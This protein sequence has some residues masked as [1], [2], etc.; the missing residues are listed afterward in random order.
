MRRGFLLMS[1][2]GSGQ[3]LALVFLRYGNSTMNYKLLA[4][5]TTLACGPVFAVQGQVFTPR[6]M[7]SGLTF[8]MVP[9]NQF[10]EVDSKNGKSDDKK[11]IKKADKKAKN[12]SK[13]S[14]ADENVKQSKNDHSRDSDAVL[15]VRAPEGRDMILLLGALPLA[16]IGPD[17]IFAE[18]PENRLLTYRNCPPGLAKKN[19]PCVPPGLARDG[20]TYDEWVTYDGDRLDAIYLERRDTYLDRDAVFDDE[21]LLLNSSQIGTLYKLRPAIADERYGLIDGQPVRLTDEDNA[22]L[23]NIFDRAQIY[24]LPEDLRIA[25]TAAF[26]Q[27]ELRETYNLPMLEPGNNYAVVNG[28]LVTLDDD[29]FETLQLIRIARAVF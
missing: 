29:A 6:V 24:E 16:L 17:V 22:V 27:D 1:I 23:L 10:I 4:L 11:K 9:E 26:T 25:P 5:A 19:P 7:I 28:E 15:T 8:R 14:K 20:V 18:V 13:N 3:Q 21:R 2:R 12:D